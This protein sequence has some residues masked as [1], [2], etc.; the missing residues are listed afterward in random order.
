MQP[1]KAGEREQFPGGAGWQHGAAHGPASE[2][3]GSGAA[4]SEELCP[5]P[6]PRAPGPAGV[7][8]LS[9]PAYAPGTMRGADSSV[10]TC[11]QPGQRRG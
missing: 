8:P 6:P 4:T 1:S 3:E 9:R 11:Q 2:R 10:P 7:A 5:L